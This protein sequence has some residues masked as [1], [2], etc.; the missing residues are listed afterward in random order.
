MAAHSARS[1]TLAEALDVAGWPQ[2]LAEDASKA[3]TVLE[4]AAAF[5]DCLL[6]GKHVDDIVVLRGGVSKLSQDGA[7]PDSVAR[8]VRMQ[9]DTRAFLGALDARLLESLR[10]RV[11]CTGADRREWE[12]RK[13]KSGAPL[14]TLLEKRR[15]LAA[16]DTSARVY[17]GELR[18][19]TQYRHALDNRHTRTLLFR[20]VKDYVGKRRSDALPYWD[21][22]DEG[23]FIGGR[24]AGSPMHVDQILWS[25]VGKNWRGHKL[26]VVWRY[27]EP[28][29]RMFDEHNYSLFLPPLAD[30]EVAALEQ[31]AQVGT[32]AARARG[33]RV[34]YPARRA[35]LASCLLL[36]YLLPRSLTSY[37]RAGGLP[38]PARAPPPR[39]R[40]APR[41]RRW[42]SSVRATA[43][44][45]Q[46][47]TPTWPSPSPR[48]S[49]SRPTNPLSTCTH[50]T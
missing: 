33:G 11:Y 17:V 4:D 10:G 16:E 26:L 40:P 37:R 43:C 3:P 50:A 24:Y 1:M 9:P 27:G 41:V 19:K 34:A 38:R 46:A 5:V 44:S 30:A 15:A 32:H 22:Y 29:R 14:D 25:N 6:W 13:S 18:R 39:C 49:P 36:S 45:S 31:A 8:A 7:L 35:S 28:S 48:P 21:R 2:S 12:L 42:L 20:D 47:A 23:V